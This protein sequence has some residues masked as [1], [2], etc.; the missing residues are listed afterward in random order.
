MTGKVAASAL[1]RH[2]VPRRHRPP[3]VRAKSVP[4]PTFLQV[5][6]CRR[7]GLDKRDR[8]APVP[9]VWKPHS[10]RL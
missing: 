5:A 3:T 8:C 2:L 6:R 4:R 10:N 1:H 9:R 7:R